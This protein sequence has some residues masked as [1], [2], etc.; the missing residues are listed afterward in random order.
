MISELVR[1]NRSYRGFD[2]SRRVEREELI[3]MVDCARLAASSVNLQPLRYYLAWEKEAVD[4]IQ[5]LT[6]W[7]RKLPELHLPHKGMCPTAFIIICQD[8]DISDSLPRFQKDVGI[9]AQTILLAAT[10]MGLGG[11]MI[12]NFK[13]GQVKEALGF[14][15]NLAPQLIV[16]IGKPAETVVIKEIEK[17]EPTDY[18]RDENDV[19]YVPKRKL[20]DVI[21]YLQPKEGV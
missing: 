18:Y 16:A 3:A 8:T 1:K 12:G 13:A 2:E 7:A 21:V 19:H 20:E 14:P 6:G 4:R 15:E 10:E 5:P 11:C 17:G 9:A